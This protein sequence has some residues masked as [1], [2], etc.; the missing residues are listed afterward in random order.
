MGRFTHDESDGRYL[1]RGWE[2]AAAVIFG[3]L[4]WGGYSLVGNWVNHLPILK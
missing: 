4:L 1:N 3:L 2:I